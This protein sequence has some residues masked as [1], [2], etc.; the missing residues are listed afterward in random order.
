MKTLLFTLEYPPWRGGVANYY[1]NLVKYWPEPSEVFV[2]DKKNGLINNWFFALLKL[3]QVVKQ[4]KINYVLVGQILPLGTATYLISKI[5]KIKYAVFLHGMDFTFAVQRPEKRWL[6][7]RILKN[8]DKIICCN[9]YVAGL[10]QKFYPEIKNKVVVVNPGVELNNQLAITNYELLK[11][12]YSLDNKIILLSIGRLV[13][14]KGFLEVIESL[15]EVLEKIPN[16]VYVII[17]D[18]V[19]LNN[20][21]T[22]I[23]ELKLSDKVFIITNVNDQERNNWLNLC[24]IFIM[25][26]KDINGDFEGFGI[27]Y[28]EA[29]MAGKPVI[30]GNSGGVGDAVIDNFNGLLVGSLASKA[31]EAKLPK[32]LSNVIIELAEDPSLRQKLGEQGRQRAIKEFNWNK[33]ARKILNIIT[34]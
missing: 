22:K 24:D 17:G 1:G 19:E 10:A 34:V 30:A 15:P 14:R 31:L 23:S 5:I 11:K 18:G 16:L 20:L 26:A 32:S 8:S 33:Q 27:V 28:L 25:P 7:K 6:I 3:W 4:K 9:N 29:N 21:Q 12:K 13:K 2:L